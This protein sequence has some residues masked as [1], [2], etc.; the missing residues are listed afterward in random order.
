MIGHGGGAVGYSIVM[1]E[2]P[3][4]STTIVA[5]NNRSDLG[6]VYM[7]LMLPALRELRR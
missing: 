1:Y 3:D 6:T 7:D 2:A 5:A 4:A